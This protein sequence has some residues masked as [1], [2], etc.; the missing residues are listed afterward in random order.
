MTNLMTRSAHD[1]HMTLPLTKSILIVLD[2]LQCL[3]SALPAFSPTF[4]Q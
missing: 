1:G 2:V 3:E 4:E